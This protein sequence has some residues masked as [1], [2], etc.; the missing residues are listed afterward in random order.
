MPGPA[1]TR[2]ALAQLKHRHAA[3][4]APFSEIAELECYIRQECADFGPLT[5]E[6]WTHVAEHSVER[7]DDGRYTLAWDPAVVRTWAGA[8]QQK[9][10]EFGSDFLFGVDLWP[11][12]NA[13]RCP[14]LVLR[15]AESELLSAATTER[16]RNSG[17]PTRIVEF[18]GIGHAPWLMSKHQINVV[19]DLLL[20]PGAQI[21]G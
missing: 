14:T 3:G 11:V 17:P 2:Q 12:W 20:A 15:G 16:M 13:V 9:A 7:L 8:G 1:T 21:V 4:H 19:C 5:D 10:I 18:A 6:Q